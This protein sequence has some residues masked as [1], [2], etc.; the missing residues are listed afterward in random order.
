M[1][2]LSFVQSHTDC[3]AL[4][5]CEIVAKETSLIEQATK[6]LLTRRRP[7]QLRRRKV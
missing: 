3:S 1:P 2:N 5:G 6:V 4:V 7:A